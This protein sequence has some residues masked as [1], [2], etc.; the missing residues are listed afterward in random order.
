VSNRETPE[1]QPVG[2][3]VLLAV[4]AYL[5]WGFL[6][7]FFLLL[8]P[9][10]ALEIVAWRVLFSLVFCAVLLTVTKAWARLGGLLR[11]RRV[12]LTLLAAGI[13]ILINWLVYVFATLNHEVVQA[14]LG[15]FTNPIVTV[16]LGIF[17]LRER[18][19]PMQWVAI[20]ISGIAVVVIAINYGA[21]P[22]IALALAFSF[23]LYGLVKKRVGTR[24]DAL[25]GLTVET[26]WLAPIA[27]AQ[28]IFVSQTSGLTIGN[29]SVL[30]T[31]CMCLAGVVTAVP[32]LLFAG[33][34]RRLPLTTIG[35]I[36]YLTPL[37]Q[38]LIGVLLLHE[39]MT[40]ARLAGFVLV[41]VALVLLS[42]DR[43]R[44][45][46]DA[47]HGTGAIVTNS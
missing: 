1:Q 40:P 7:L 12:L 45:Q 39:V 5:M 41:W 6:P 14:A 44:A 11:D 31:V 37:M 25:S 16:L 9:A 32:L 22:W 30:Q 47:R 10:N 2:R 42:V 26:M 13:L 21:F 29:I 4:L 8:A 43:F 28:L 23:G 27:I 20:G 38:F 36:Q 35:L 3:G 24:V 33:A 34:A 19:R 18:L 15:Y 46:R 17:V